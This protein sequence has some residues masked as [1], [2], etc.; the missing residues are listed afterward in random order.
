MCSIH[1]ELWLSM[2]EEGFS[3]FHVSKWNSLRSNLACSHQ[4]Q[5]GTRPLR[6][7]SMAEV[8]EQRICQDENHFRVTKKISALVAHC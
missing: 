4:H 7:L 6:S 3:V 5:T 8:G 1:A 2:G